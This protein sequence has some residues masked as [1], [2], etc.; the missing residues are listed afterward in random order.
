MFDVRC[1]ECNMGH[2]TRGAG[3]LS[4]PETSKY[5]SVHLIADFN[6][7]CMSSVNM[8]LCQLVFKSVMVQFATYTNVKK[9]LE[10]SENDQYLMYR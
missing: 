10:T 8:T 2:L 3:C 7:W 6:M 5:L 4:S 9:K 1:A